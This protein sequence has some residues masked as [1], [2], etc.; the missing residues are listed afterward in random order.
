M[1]KILIVCNR[2][3][4]RRDKN[5]EVWRAHPEGNWIGNVA[6]EELLCEM[7]QNRKTR[8]NK[9]SRSCKNSSIL[10]RK[11]KSEKAKTKSIKK[12]K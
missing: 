3:V 9:K 1:V 2:K 8:P 11:G 10:K 4:E 5:G 12:D 7:I 6:G